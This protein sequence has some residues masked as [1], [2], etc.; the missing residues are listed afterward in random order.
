[1]PA[2]AQRTDD[3]AK[4]LNFV[5]SKE[6][7]AAWSNITGYIPA[8]ADA[9]E[10]TKLYSKNGKARL[11]AVQAMEIAVVRPIHPAY[12]VISSAFGKAL[13]SIFEGADAQKA[14]DKAAST[15]DEDIEDNNGYPP[16][17]K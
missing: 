6:Q 2:K 12:P 5:L 11:F 16:F 17:N 14:L 1:V 8:R 4:F 3:I 7:V 15:I 13:S 10:L 9:A